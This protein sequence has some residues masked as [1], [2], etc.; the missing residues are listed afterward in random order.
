MSLPRRVRL[1]QRRQGALS[2]I[3]VAGTAPASLNFGTQLE[4]TTSPAQT[5][6]VS[7]TGTAALAISSISISGN[8]L[9]SSNG[10][11]SSLAQNSSCQIG[12][13]FT[14][15]STGALSGTLTITDNNNGLAGSTQTVSLSGTGL[16]AFTI[17]P[18]PSTETVYRGVLGVFILTLKSLGGFDGKVTLSCSGGPAGSYCTDLPQTVNL[19]GTAYAVSG[20]LFPKNTT[21]G[22]YVI[23]FT[24][25]SGAVTAKATATFIV[26]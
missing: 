24:G 8:F 22:T 10:C 6:T 1:V 11:G 23:T 13:T 2:R 26:K 15:Q 18:A 14:P 20:I 17:T 9:I 5:A 12:I 25:T 19:N 3:P 21:P 4:G 16:G 7:N